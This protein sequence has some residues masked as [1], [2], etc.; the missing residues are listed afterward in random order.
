VLVDSARQHRLAFQHVDELPAPRWPD[1]AAPQQLHLDFI[2]PTKQELGV[3]H[4]R[5]LSLGATLLEDR[6][7][8]PAEALYVYADPAG[9]PFCIL[10]ANPAAGS[11][12]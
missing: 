1:P 9:H 6:F 10:V 4:W 2:V 8:D 3:Q 5:A 12:Y 11:G 7:D